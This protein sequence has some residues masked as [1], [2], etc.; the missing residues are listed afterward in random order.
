MS[1]SM[2][3]REW[4][5][6]SQKRKRLHNEKAKNKLDRSTQVSAR[7]NQTRT[8]CWFNQQNRYDPI[9]FAETG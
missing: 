3:W 2:D 5:P 6:S 9:V 1:L 4:N 8:C 7:E